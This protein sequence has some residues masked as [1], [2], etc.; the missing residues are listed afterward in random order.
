VLQAGGLLCKQRARRWSRSVAK[1]AD[2]CNCREKG[3]R[4]KRRERER[5]REGAME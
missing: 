2:V 5:E 4:R 1:L 3:E